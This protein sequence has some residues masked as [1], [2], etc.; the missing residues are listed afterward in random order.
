MSRNTFFH[1]RGTVSSH[2]AFKQLRFVFVYFA[3]FTKK[4][5]LMISE[6]CEMLISNFRN[7]LKIKS[8]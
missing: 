4:N 1:C 2:V 3:A 7:C 6:F 5:S 8:L